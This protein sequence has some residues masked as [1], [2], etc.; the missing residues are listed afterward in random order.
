MLLVRGLLESRSGEEILFTGSGDG[1]VKL[2]ELGQGTN[3]APTEIVSLQNGNESVLS[4]AV[5]GP[6]LYCGL[7]GGAINVW[8]LDSHQIIKTITSHTADIWAIDIIK[9]TIISGDSDGAVKVSS[10][11]PV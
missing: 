2:W 8:N 4:I 3:V 6:F 1:S 11:Y 7:T 5:D 10:L 9:G